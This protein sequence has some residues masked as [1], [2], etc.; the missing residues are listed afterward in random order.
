MKAEIQ[1]GLQTLRNLGWKVDNY[2][3][4]AESCLRFGGTEESRLRQLEMP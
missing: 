2:Y 3:H 4:H 1:C